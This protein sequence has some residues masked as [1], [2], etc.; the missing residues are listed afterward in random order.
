MS[1]QDSELRYF[2]NRLHDSLQDG[3]KKVIIQMDNYH[4]IKLLELFKFNKFPTLRNES[5]NAM[6]KLVQI[7]LH[8]PILDKNELD[9]IISPLQ[10]ELY[11]GNIEPAVIACF[12]DRQY[13][14]RNLQPLFDC[15][16]CYENEKK[17]ECEYTDKVYVNNLRA[18]YFV[19]LI[20]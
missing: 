14:I 17:I 18:K 5:L 7:L 13:Q 12:L 10:R 20:K 6:S 2:K 4:K 8:L 11:A 16:K 1:I 15:F 3:F 9:L 19:P